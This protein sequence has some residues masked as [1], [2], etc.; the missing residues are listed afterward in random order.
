MPVAGGEVPLVVFPLVGAAVGADG[1]VGIVLRGGGGGGRE[2]PLVG[3][4][5][6]VPARGADLLDLL[7]HG[8][9]RLLAWNRRGSLELS[10]RTTNG[11]MEE[12]SKIQS[13]GI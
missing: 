12:K 5:A 8:G 4:P 6:S 10:G 3:G 7:G 9:G 2:R 1:P 13:L 11:S